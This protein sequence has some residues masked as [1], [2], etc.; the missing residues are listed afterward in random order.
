MKFQH[1]M[2]LVVL[3]LVTVPGA[4]AATSTWTGADPS[5]YWS[6]PAN[7]S[8]AGV[9]V[10]GDAL[11]F[12]AGLPPGDKVSTNDLADG[13][14]RSISLASGHTIRGNRITLTNDTSVIINS[15]TNEI[16]CDW[17]FTATSSPSALQN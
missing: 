2:A 10:N 16:A 13:L 12:P 6:A 14:F 11:V 4:R 7:W 1:L 17:T 9:P 3:S 15:G 5:G 8:P